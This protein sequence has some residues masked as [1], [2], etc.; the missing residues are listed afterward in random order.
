MMV[1]QG[2]AGNNFSFIS[3]F[4]LLLFLLGIARWPCKKIIPALQFIF[5][6]DSVPLLLFAIFLIY[7]DYFELDFIFNFI[8]SHLIFEIYF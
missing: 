4:L 5:S 1:Q 6:L 8:P 2:L 3:F 7:I